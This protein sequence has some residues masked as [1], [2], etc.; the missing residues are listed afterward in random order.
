MKKLLP[1]I[2]L[3]LIA[4][5]FNGC[6][7]DEDNNEDTATFAQIQGNW[8]LTGYTD[9]TGTTAIVDGYEIQFN[10]DKS[11]T[12]NEI[13][14]YTG[15]TYRVTKSPGRN[16]QLIYKKTW[17]SIAAYKYINNVDSNHIYLQASSND[18]IADG[19]SFSSN[20]ILT[21]IP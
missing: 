1:T 2:S 5:L 19:T 4:L 16:F 20:Y 10:E 11:F 18:P 3:I 9:G 6:T 12:S 15:G 8:K 21:R 13:D 14:G 17:S 7:A